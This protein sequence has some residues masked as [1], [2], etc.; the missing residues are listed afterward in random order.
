MAPII[1]TMA[2][3][4]T[5]C[6][7]RLR[8]AT[9]IA[10]GLPIQR[11]FSTTPLPRSKALPS[12]QPTSNPELDALFKDFRYKHFLPATLDGAQQK[13][14]FKRS[15]R[16]VLQENPQTVNIGGEEFQLEH[17]G[18]WG[19]MPNRKKQ[20]QHVLRLLKTGDPNDWNNLPSLLQ[21]L[22]MMGKDPS[23]RVRARIVR[24]A[25]EREKFGVVLACLN[26]ARNTGL[27][28]K[29][30]EVLEQ[31]IWSLRQ[32]AEDG[33]WSEEA[34]AKAIKDANDV[35]SQLESDAHGSGKHVGKEDPR[36]SPY[37]LGIF[38]E[39]AAVYAS[40]FKGGEDIDGKVRAFADR[41]LSNI[42]EDKKAVSI[43]LPIYASTRQLII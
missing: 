17:L 31:V 32:V 35:A 23:P 28:L 18:G 8:R 9:D 41:L 6:A 43:T 11:L 33:E 15:K 42:S 7:L 36:R 4:C 12:F 1:S 19:V 34:T 22:H 38:L 13:L 16:N 5:R 29:D 24:M 25:T 2:S 10:N 21:G 30:P 3:L 37:V 39:L 20:L 14:V 40:R 26:S 27:T